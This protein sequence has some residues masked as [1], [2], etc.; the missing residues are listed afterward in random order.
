MGAE[1]TVH[2]LGLLVNC[3]QYCRLWYRGFS[4]L[5]NHIDLCYKVIIYNVSAKNESIGF[6]C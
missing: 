3:T 6:S 5:N 2:I 1:K 4:S